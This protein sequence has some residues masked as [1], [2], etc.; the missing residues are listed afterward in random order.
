MF[1]PLFDNIRSVIP[2]TSA[3]EQSLTPYLRLQQ[4]RKKQKLLLAGKVCVLMSFVV[5]GVLRAYHQSEHDQDYTLYFTAEGEWSL[6]QISFA[7]QQPSELCIEALED[8]E[9]ITIDYHSWQLVQVQQPG[10]RTFS[11]HIL[12]QRL[13]QEQARTLSLLRDSASVR[14]VRFLQEHPQLLQRIPQKYIASYLGISA[15]FLS[16]IRRQLAL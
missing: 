10:L 5:R 13:M 4:V 6:D 7:Q 14:Y 8:A 1:E 15:E 9:L 12:R 11:Q 2:F 16:K 3:D